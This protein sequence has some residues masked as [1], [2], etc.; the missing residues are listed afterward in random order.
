VVEVCQLG[1]PDATGPP[2]G[3]QMNDLSRACISVVRA[4][5]AAVGDGVVPNY[6]EVRS[7]QGRMS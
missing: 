2:L 4:V 1:Y 3:F 7:E 5:C 6:G